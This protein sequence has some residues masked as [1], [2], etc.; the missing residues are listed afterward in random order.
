MH[1]LPFV[2]LAKLSCS[3]SLNS[4]DLLMFALKLGDGGYVICYE[5]ED[6]EKKLGFGRKSLVCYMFYPARVDLMGYAAT[7]NLILS[8]NA[9]L[10][11][12]P[13]VPKYKSF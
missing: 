7:N 1:C 3:C 13:S 10:Q 11:N 4:C 2:V 6:I 5:M 12:T 9:I 8:R